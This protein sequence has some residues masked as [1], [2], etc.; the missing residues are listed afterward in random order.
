MKS[1]R[2]AMELG[3][4]AVLTMR[5]G[6]RSPLVG[7]VPVPGLLRLSPLRPSDLPP[8]RRRWSQPR[9]THRPVGGSRGRQWGRP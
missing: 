1:R 3:P 5:S 2:K 7:P 6:L 9:L 4:E 8:R